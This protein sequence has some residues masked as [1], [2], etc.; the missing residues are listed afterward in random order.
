MAQPRPCSLQKGVGADRAQSLRH[1]AKSK[2]QVEGEVQHDPVY[3]GVGEGRCANAW[4]GVS[5]Q[6]RL[7]AGVTPRRNEPGQGPAK[8]NFDFSLYS[9]LIC[10]ASQQ[11]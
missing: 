9:S 5:G 2:N 8:G 11:T 7:L 1:T 3:W 4:R 6:A 10:L